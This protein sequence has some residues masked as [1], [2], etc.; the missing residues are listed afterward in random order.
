MPAE[1]SVGDLFGGRIVFPSPEARER[2]NGLVGIDDQKRR[3]EAEISLRVNP[4]RLRTWFKRNYASAEHAESLLLRRPP[5]VVL[6]GDVGCGKTALAESI[7]DAV[8]RNQN[9]DVTLFPLSL[10]SRGQGRVG[11]MTQLLS[12]AFNQI[13]MEGRRA[14]TNE[15]GGRAGIILLIDEA[16]ALAQSRE[17]VQMHHEDRAGVNALIR[18][19]DQL[20]EAQVPV[21]VIMCTNRPG[22]LDPAVRRRAADILLFDRPDAEQRSAA[23]T[24]M[25]HGFGFSDEETQN[26]AAVTGQTEGREYGFTFSDLTQR[27]IPAIVLDTYPERNVVGAQRAIEIARSM[28]ATAPFTESF[29]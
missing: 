26:L 5:L 17:E 8:A 12:S 22:A 16:D 10:A 18:G 7:G 11:E 21:M 24:K 13:L 19:I 15:G 2:L 29:R 27:L 14:R 23:L 1:H 28:A 3:L 25:L 6:A 9:L 20:A 4:Q